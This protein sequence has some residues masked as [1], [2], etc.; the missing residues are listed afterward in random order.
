M[1][2]HNKGLIQDINWLIDYLAH[3]GAD[4]KS[5]GLDSTADDYQLCI[6]VIS[7]LVDVIESVDWVD[8][9]EVDITAIKEFKEGYY[10]NAKKALANIQLRAII[11]R[12]AWS[13]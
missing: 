6:N 8:E 10:W 11:I 9:D 1:S 7:Q 13:N 3:T 5:S 2:C 12:I 4:H